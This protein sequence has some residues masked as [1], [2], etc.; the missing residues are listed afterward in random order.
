MLGRYS[1]ALILVMIEL[2]LS[3]NPS[4]GEAACE[5]LVQS[6]CQGL[7]YNMTIVPNSFGHRS[8][9]QALN[10]LQPLVPLVRLPSSKDITFFLCSLYFP[11]C[12]ILETAIPPCRSLCLRAKSG[13]EAILKAFGHTWP[14]KL[15]CQ[16]FPE[17]GRGH[18]C[19]FQNTS[20]SPTPTS[21]VT[22][23]KI[24]FEN[25]SLNE[26]E[27]QKICWKS[28]VGTNKQC[29]RQGNKA[30]KLGLRKC[31]LGKGTKQKLSRKKKRFMKKTSKMCSADM[32]TKLC[33]QSCCRYKKKQF[34]I[35]NRAQNLRKTKRRRP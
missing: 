27:I 15:D 11:M 1:C 22:P 35:K 18:T 16:R 5:P 21:P 31:S 17:L 30:V 24:I 2:L 6:F 10:E 4:H 9:R 14:K 8:Q 25:I 7:G 33:Y 23:K 13:S 34:L 29:C 20:S 26:K 3:Q 19:I 28:D 12:T 32:M